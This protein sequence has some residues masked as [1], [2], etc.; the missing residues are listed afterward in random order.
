MTG[1]TE[2]YAYATG[3]PIRHPLGYTI[4]IDT[5]LDW[6]GVTDHSEY[7]GTVRLAN[8]PSSPISKLPIAERLKVRTKADIQKIYLWLGYSMIDNKPI[9]ELLVPEIAGTVWKENNAI[10]DRFNKPRPVHRVL[11]LRMDLDAEQPEHA[12]QR[13]LQGLRQGPGDAVQ[14]HRL[15]EPGGPLGLDGRAAQGRH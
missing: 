10:A 5:P 1:P 13:V 4:K 11:R 6:M 2:A 9:K 15:H 14:L 8:D 3:E 12:P 7:V